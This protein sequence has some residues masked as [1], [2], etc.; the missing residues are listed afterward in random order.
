[1]LSVCCLPTQYKLRMAAMGWFI[2]SLTFEQLSKVAV[3][4]WPYAPRNV[5]VATE[6]MQHWEKLTEQ[7]L[8]M[9]T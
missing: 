4:S 8:Q 5:F 2:G 3:L 9:A 7:R 1:V 6:V